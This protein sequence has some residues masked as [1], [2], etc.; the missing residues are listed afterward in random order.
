MKF[1]VHDGSE[2][3]RLE[4]SLFRSLGEDEPSQ[5]VRR[6]VA[7][8]L[9]VGALGLAH[10]TL[11]GASSLANAAPGS[12]VGAVLVLKW[13]SIG[14]A[15]GALSAGGAQYA[16]DV[17][18]RSIAA[19]AAPAA[20]SRAGRRPSIAS[21][22]S[23][24]TLASP[25]LPSTTDATNPPENTAATP[26]RSLAKRPA[27]ADPV[28]AT[29]VA[30]PAA[31]QASDRALPSSLGAEVALLDRVRTALSSQDAVAAGALLNQYARD[32]PKGTLKLEARVFLVEEL[33]L[34]GDAKQ[35]TALGE[36]ILRWPG[37]GTHASRI[38]SLLLQ[39]QKP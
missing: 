23:A 37:V 1:D 27:D 3:A 4:A 26:A 7:S 2:L 21:A 13:L 31:S 30:E 5:D 38:R 10:G 18:N 12:K 6:R 20:A 25:S 15:A 19:T 14:L 39:H 11:A 9:G 16:F 17:S 36:E 35:A 8:A 22:G 34:R 24:A 32:F 28:A 33:F 29:S